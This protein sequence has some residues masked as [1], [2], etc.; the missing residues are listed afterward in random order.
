MAR[1]FEMTQNAVLT[2]YTAGKT[3]TEDIKVNVA[4]PG[5]DVTAETEAYTEKL[6]VLETAITELENELDGKINGED[7]GDET[8]VYTDKLATLETAITELETELQ[9]KASSVE[10]PELTNEG[11]SSDLLSGKQLI[12]GDGN[13]VEGTITNNGSI[14]STMDGIET[15]SIA[16]PAGYTSGGSISLDS[17]IDNEVD[18]QSYLIAQIKSTVNSLP[19]AGSGSGGG[20]TYTV[21]IQNPPSNMMIGV[22]AVFYMGNTGVVQ[23][24]FYLSDFPVQ[25]SSVSGILVLQDVMGVGLFRSI[26]EF[27]GCVSN[28]GYAMS[29]VYDVTR[30]L[31]INLS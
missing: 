22:C 29:F 3:C 17:T 26:T 20:Q 28:D 24:T 14:F 11:T 2:L 31:I 13:I 7:V 16:I 23:E 9:G 19:E 10:L 30:D 4:V 18:E 1:Q 15:K 25:L 5:E 8:E 12:D 21:T 27:D 6:L